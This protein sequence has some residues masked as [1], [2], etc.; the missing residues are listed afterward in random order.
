[1]DIQTYI[2]KAM[3]ADRALAMANSDQLTL[4]EILSKC[5]AIAK[6]DRGDKD[7]PCVQFDFEHLYPTDIDSWRGSYDELSLSFSSGFG[8]M[9]LS[10]FIE[11]LTS[12]VGKEF[13]GWKGGEYIMNR[14]TPVW[15][16]N[17]GNSGNTAVVEVVDQGYV[18]TLMTAYREFC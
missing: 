13:T 1:M 16:A 14:H 8:E 2:N 6:N 10:A 4:G 9:K 15:V 18:V 17:P 12:A 5:E 7:E 3:K 11:L